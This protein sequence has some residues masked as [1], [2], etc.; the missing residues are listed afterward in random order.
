MALTES[1]WQELQDPGINPKLDQMID[2]LRQMA[3]NLA[4]TRVTNP[5]AS[6]TGRAVRGSSST[7]SSASS[8]SPHGLLEVLPGGT[9]FTL[10]ETLQRFNALV[11]AAALAGAVPLELTQE[12]V[13]NPGTTNSFVYAVP[14]GIVSIAMSGARGYFTRHSADIRMNGFVNYGLPEAQPITE[15][16]IP[17]THDFAINRLVD[18]SHEIKSNLTILF[19]NDSPWVV[20]VT[21]QVT[22][23]Q[24]DQSLWDTMY[25]P[26]FRQAVRVWMEGLAQDARSI[27]GQST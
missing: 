27:G 8:G 1:W 3:D 12:V 23:L 20:T 6:D 10:P 5:P 17:A 2:L 13:I 4:V 26:I 22:L 25:Y 16:D 11:G 19:T 14:E 21:I 9:V 18:G 15:P 24:V 7:A